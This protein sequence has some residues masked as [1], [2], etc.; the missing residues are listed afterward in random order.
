ME[1]I[2]AGL[3]TRWSR[4]GTGPRRGLFLHCSLASA[5]SLRPVREALGD[6]LTSD[7]PD[8]PGHGGSGDWDG[9]GDYLTRASQ[10]AETFCDGPT[11][12]IGHSLGGVVALA[13]MARRPDLVRSAVLVEPVFFAAA[14]GTAAHDSYRVDHATMRERM[15]VGDRMGAT[16]A[17]TGLWGTGTWDG[18]PDAVREAMAARIHLIAETRPGLD[19]DSTGILA[20]GRLSSIPAPVL[21]VRGADTHPVIPEVFRTLRARL[22]FAV[23]AVVPGAGHMAP[24]THAAKVAAL[25][26]THMERA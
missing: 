5:R 4:V 20:D 7:A 23:E 10:M 11:D 3:R 8:L 22:P 24:I 17:F 21:L 9:Q 19:G 14:R 18:L 1:G 25:I 2:R 12:L 13:L 6:V 26:R 16:R 15:A